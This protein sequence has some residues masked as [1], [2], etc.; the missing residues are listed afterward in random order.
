MAGGE[1]ERVV[2]DGESRSLEVDADP[3]IALRAE[4]RNLNLNQ[5]VLSPLGQ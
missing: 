5:M 3:Q 2:I 1:V 4:I